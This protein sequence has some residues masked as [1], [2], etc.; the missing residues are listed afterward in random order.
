MLRTWTDRLVD[1]SGRRP[2]WV[3]LPTLLVLVATWGYASRLELR[4]D[5][6]ELLPRDSPGYAA[7]EHQLGRLGGGASLIVVVESPDRAANER[8]V[9]DIN[10]RIHREMSASE[11]GSTGLRSL[12]SYVEGNA[13][14]L[15]SYYERTKWLYPSAHELER[16]EQDLDFEVAS[17]AGLVEDLES[18]EAARPPAI[19]TLARV[20]PKSGA[21]IFDDFPSGYFESSDG[22]SAAI[23]IISSSGGTGDRA[24]DEL[25]A[26]VEKI[27]ADVHPETYQPNMRVGY[28]GDVPNAI[29]EKRSLVGD[30]FLA[31]A[32]ALF[33]VLAGVA[34][35][36]RSLVAIVIIGLPAWF[37]VGCAYAFAT[38]TFG[39]VNTTG[40]F[41]GAIIVGNGINYPIVLLSRYREFVRD[42]QSKEAAKRNAVANAFRAELVGACVGSIAYGSLVVTRFRGFSQFGWIGFVGMLAVWVATILVVPALTALF[43]RRGGTLWDGKPASGRATAALAGL[44]ARHRT[45]IL[46]LSV[47]LVA[48]AAMKLPKYLADPWEYDFDKLGSRGSKSQGAGYWSNR[49]DAI[50]GKVNI[51]GASMLADEPRQ[52]PALKE[53][54]LANDGADPEGRLIAAVVT[55]DDFL[56]GS[57]DEQHRKLDILARLRRRLTPSFM[58]RLSPDDRKVAETLRPPDTLATVA[59]SDL[60]PLL[61]RRFQEKDGRL[62][63]VFYVRYQ[64]NVSLSDGHNL[65]RIAKATDNV[66]LPDGTVVQTASRAT[67]F[68]EMIRS[69]ER[70]GPLSTG[71]SFLAVLLVMFVATHDWKGATTVLVALVGGVVLMVGGAA[72]I[73]NKL[74]FL[75]FIALPITFGIGCEY[76][77]NVYDRSRLLGGDVAGALRRSGGAV[78]LCSYTTMIGYA[79]LLFADNQ[80]LQSFGWMAISGEIACAMMALV[81]LPALLFPRQPIQIAAPGAPV[82]DATAPR[83]GG[84]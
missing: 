37:G 71:A 76:P 79:A 53:R 45:P 75:N 51:A 28:A 38:L 56:P 5:L 36:F 27:V 3:L 78:A 68:A 48:V 60:P 35:F 13:K 23:R 12:V 50:F 21:R 41:L 73:G 31:T 40:A 66:T 55:I 67:I 11:G 83:A 72:L 46:A 70:D 77:F 20:E 63:T 26:R 4:S 64:D 25:L 14:D 80:A 52:V 22:T 17:R 69:L 58:A 62:G 6:R 8:L 74:N 10:E 33:L 44:V 9:D 59:S 39:Y 19:P 81:L 61:R 18:S 29:E 1:L 84:S 24:G 54:I 15:R 57:I 2:L 7:F 34:W 82:P 49:A 65:L 32:L 30:A 47:A 43:E 42:G 16:M